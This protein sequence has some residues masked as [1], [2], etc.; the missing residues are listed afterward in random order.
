[1]PSLFVALGLACAI[2]ILAANEPR[3]SLTSA[4]LMVV[5]LALV[6]RLYSGLRRARSDRA[7]LTELVKQHAAGAAAVN[8]LARLIE[9]QGRCQ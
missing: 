6:G 4:G 5:C 3:W 8:R 7:V 9:T 2:G 1:V